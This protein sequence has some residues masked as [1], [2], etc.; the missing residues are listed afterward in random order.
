MQANCSKCSDEGCNHCAEADR[1][2][3]TE[4][5]DLVALL[6][7]FAICV[8]SQ[9]K[10]AR[11]AASTLHSLR[12]T[13]NKQQRLMPKMWA[14]QREENLEWILLSLVALALDVPLQDADHVACVGSTLQSAGKLA[15]NA[16][17]S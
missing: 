5:M 17:P 4:V 6:E 12:I 10:Y 13:T 15:Q 7:T 3:D 9:R 1:E 14:Q 8:F 16:A 2:P 11:V